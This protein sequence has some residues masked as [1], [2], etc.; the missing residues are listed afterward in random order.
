[1]FNYRFLRKEQFEFMG[2]EFFFIYA[3][4]TAN[5]THVAECRAAQFSKDVYCREDSHFPQINY[6]VNNL[7]AT[8]FL[9]NYGDVLHLVA[10]LFEEFPDEVFIY[11]VQKRDMFS[12]PIIMGKGWEGL[13]QSVEFLGHY[14]AVVLRHMK[15]IVFYDMKQCYD[16]QDKVCE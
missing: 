7:T 15:T 3:Q 14:L 16:H 10:V 8:A 9:P 4:D 6:K 13:I 2:D 11:D 1:M 12:K 5:V